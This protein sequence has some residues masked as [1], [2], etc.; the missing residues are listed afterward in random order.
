MKE[1]NISTISTYDS[2]LMRHSNLINQYEVIE[3]LRLS[4]SLTTTIE[5]D[6]WLELIINQNHEKN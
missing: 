5:R 2:Q 3:E 1:I 6:I 4:T